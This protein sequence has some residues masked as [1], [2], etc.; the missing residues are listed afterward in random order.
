M[1]PSLT[2]EDPP[3]RVDHYGWTLVWLASLTLIMWLAVDA[4]KSPAL[5]SAG[6]T[7]QERV[8]TLLGSAL[9]IIGVWWTFLGEKT[10]SGERHPRRL[11]WPTA[12]RWPGVVGL[13]GADVWGSVPEFASGIIGFLIGGMLIFVSLLGLLTF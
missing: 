8:V 12:G 5:F 1:D 7:Q 2:P 4:V 10:S 13:L 6:T 3:A 11:R 9:G